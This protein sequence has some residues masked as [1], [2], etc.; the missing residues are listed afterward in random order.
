[1]TRRP[2]IHTG[3]PLREG[4][5][6]VL[7]PQPSRHIARVLRLGPG[8]EITLFDGHGNEFR[9]H[10]Q[11]VARDAVTVRVA[12]QQL[13]TRESPLLINLIQGI[14]RGERMDYAIQKAV[15]LGVARIAPVFCNRTLVKLDGER[16]Q[17]RQQHWQAVA[18]SA[19]EQ[20]GRAVVPP[21][22]A[23]R[24]LA[25]HLG[26][27]TAE[28]PGL[29]LDPRGTAALTT[30]PGPGRVTLLIG[31]EG[32]L[33]QHERELAHERGFVGVRMGPRILRTE[34]AAAAAI[35]VMQA[36]WGDLGE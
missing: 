26:Q 16:L 13:G 12:R 14:S 3:R 29:L 20:C 25:Q 33:E 8:A 28:A 34:T 4:A 9:A 36:L 18:R 1:M 17:R 2:R 6:L 32:G 11:Q 24:P 27:T 35:A 5:T 10:V 23:P 22:A 19:S 31:P 7:E 21:V 15:E 30:L